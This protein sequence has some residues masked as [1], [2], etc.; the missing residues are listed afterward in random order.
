M[1]NDDLPVGRV[2]DRREA[3]KLLA[4]TGAAVLAGCNR[5]SAAAAD[6]SIVASTTAVPGCIVRPELTV[7]PYFVDH[8]LER[9]DITTDPGTGIASPG[10]PLDLTFTVSQISGG[11]CLPLEG[12]V[13]DVWH[14]DASGQYSAVNDRM[15]GF[16]TLDK[17]FLRGF[18][19]TSDIGVARFKTIYPGWYRGRT[20]HIHFKIR[21]PYANKQYDFT[22]QLFFDDAFS[23]KIFARAPYNAKGN[24]DLRNSDDGIFRQGGNSLLLSVYEARTNDGKLVLPYVATFDIALDLSA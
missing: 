3:V 9:S 15:E 4:V 8:Q 18:Q 20:V 17:K 5:S 12:A 22:S 21:A 16:N 23:D 6:T 10:V 13:V 14:C 7:G 1:D 2:L 19:K 11:K 24:R